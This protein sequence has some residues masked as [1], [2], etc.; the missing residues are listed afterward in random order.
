MQATSGH[1]DHRPSTLPPS[2]RLPLSFP[3]KLLDTATLNVLAG[4]LAFGLAACNPVPPVPP[5]PEPSLV[6]SAD[7]VSIIRGQGA[8]IVLNLE[9][10]GGLAS[11]VTLAIT[12]LPANVTAVFTPSS[13]DN[14]GL[15]STLSIA[16]QPG[17]AESSSVL[18][19]TATGADLA[20]QADLDLDV[21]GLTINGRVRSL[22]SSPLAGQHVSSQG[23]ATTTAE[24]GTFTLTGLSWPYDLTVHRFNGAGSVHVFEGLTSVAPV[25]WPSDTALLSTVVPKLATVTGTV[26]A[27]AAVPAGDEVKVCFEGL[28]VVVIDCDTVAA[29]DATFELS[30]RWFTAASPAV[31]VHALHYLVTADGSVGAYHGY[32]SFDLT[33]SDGAALTANV[34]ALDS[35]PAVLVT[36]A[37]DAPEPS[38]VDS[39]YVAARF[40]DNLA[41]PLPTPPVTNPDGLYALVP[42]LPGVTYDLFAG[43]SSSLVW[44]AAV[45]AGAVT[46]TLPPLPE[47]TAPAQATMGVDA[48]TVFSAETGGRVAVYHWSPQGAGPRVA[49]TTTRSAVTIPAS[50]ALGLPIPGGASYTWNVRTQDTADVDVAAAEG[51]VVPIELLAR[52]NVGGQGMA[53]SGGLATSLETRTF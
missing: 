5:D 18:T 35:V 22:F 8:D 42:S 15:T 51:E 44:R 16:V 39:V 52:P 17:A 19:I 28:E 4:L 46:L 20:L 36:I 45:P 24:D 41:L 10:A 9:D 23:E 2:S 3:K 49:L 29:G 31:R 25:V 48:S 7:S 13:L 26:L 12:G 14:G 32:A 50:A 27:G 37:F 21:L 11:T 34:P 30:A 53:A 47:L 33:L 43:T 40:S 1:W 6:L 38:A